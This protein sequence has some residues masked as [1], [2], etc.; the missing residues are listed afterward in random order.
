MSYG[1]IR[2]S[3]SKIKAAAERHFKRGGPG[4]KLGAEVSVLRMPTYRGGGWHYEAEACLRTTGGWGQKSCGGLRG[5]RTPQSA[6][7][8]ALKAL[9]STLAM[10]GSKRAYRT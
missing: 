8:K 1:R 2:R 10:R 5:G 7:G 4:K 3:R 9:G 6:I